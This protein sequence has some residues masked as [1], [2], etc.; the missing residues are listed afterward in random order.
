VKRILR[1]DAACARAVEII[2]RKFLGVSFTGT[3]RISTGRTRSQAAHL[4]RVKPISAKS[5]YAATATVFLY[6]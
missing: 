2:W 4:I 5:T 1:A 3:A 6:T